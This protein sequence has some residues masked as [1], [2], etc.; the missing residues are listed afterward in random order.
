MPRRSWS[1]FALLASACLAHDEDPAIEPVAEVPSDRELASAPGSARTASAP[2]PAPAPAPEASED[3]RA[4]D[5]PGPD[6]R[7]APIPPT[8][9]G[10]P[11]DGASLPVDGELAREALAHGD[12]GDGETMRATWLRLLRDHPQSPYV[13]LAYVAFGDHY[14]AEGKP[15]EASNLYDKALQFPEAPVRAWALYKLAWCNL[16]RGDGA[17]ALD[18][19]VQTLAAIE[20]GHAGNSSDAETLAAA[21]RRDLVIAYALAGKPDKAAVFFQRLGKGKAADDVPPAKMLDLLGR[22]LTRDG[23]AA[24]ASV[25]CEARKQADARATCD[26]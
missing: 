24:E 13:P 25:I 1:L 10:R 2:A 20:A 9:A 8:R 6:D 17:G 7:D 16:Q 4:A 12:A 23:K 21:T 18:R 19:F 11:P 14:F 26:W 22:R 3:P 15:E 5:P